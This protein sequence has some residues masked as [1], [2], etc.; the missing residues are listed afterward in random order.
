MGDDFDAYG[1]CYHHFIMRMQIK[2]LFL[3]IVCVKPH[4]MTPQT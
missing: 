3:K 1:V 2:K 4:D